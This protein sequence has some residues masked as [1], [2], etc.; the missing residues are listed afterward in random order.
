MPSSSPLAQEKNARQYT[1]YSEMTSTSPM[2]NTPLTKSWSYSMNARAD[3]LSKPSGFVTSTEVNN[4]SSTRQI[5]L[6]DG[7]RFDDDGASDNDRPRKRP[8]LSVDSVIAVSPGSPPSPEIIRAGQ[9]RKVAA[10]RTLLS[11]SSISS[12]ES[13]PAVSS[14]VA[15]SSKPRIARG[16]APVDS[17]L[18]NLRVSHAW[19]PHDHVDVAYHRS[20]GNVLQATRLLS[21]PDFNPKAK[22]IPPVSMSVTS[23]PDSIRVVG[24]VK[25]VEEER[26]AARM[27][28]KE[29]AAKSSIYKRRAT[30]DQP[31]PSGS[32]PPPSSTVIELDSSPVRPRIVRGNPRK[33][34]DSASEDDQSEDEIQLP[35]N[36]PTHKALDSL[37]TLSSD[38]LVQLTG[39]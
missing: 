1:P 5:S 27:H 23:T 15:G 6:A 30:V 29:I 17:K 11:S 36:S 10:S 26:E 2:P 21:D 37:N 22:P 33:V 3:P 19:L 7:R 8:N 16:A 25:E 28:Q 13:L 18:Q 39:E 34:I 14:L 24:K 4:A 20:N 35:R 12:D 32:A 9:K 38:A 31:S